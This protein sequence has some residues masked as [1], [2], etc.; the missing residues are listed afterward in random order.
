MLT[1]E[2]LKLK[3]KDLIAHKHEEEWF[4]FK[5]NWFEPHALGEYISALSNAAT[6]QGEEYGFFVWGVED[7]T[8]NV[9]GSDFDFHQDVKNEP[10]KHY[11]ARQTEP[12]IGF[13]F[14]EVT[15]EGKRLVVLA[16]PAA[17]KM[18]TAFDNVRYIRIGS[19]KE[20]LMRY[21]E[22]ESQ[23]FYVLR[24]G[25]P[26]I[27][28]TA[29]EY[30]DLTFN[31]LFVYFESK[32]VALSRRTFKKNLGLLTSEGKYN[33]LAQLLSDDSHI[34]IRF[35]LF[36]GDT[37]ASTMY[38]VKEF[39]YTCLLYSLDQVLDYGRVLNIPQAD[40]RD[41]RTVRKE[42]PLFNAEVYE[43]AVINAFV[44]NRWL[45]GNAPM[46]TGFR[47]RMEILS[48]G[49][50]PPKQTL[51]GFYD[52]VSVPVN[53]ALSRI[54][55]MLHITEHTGRGIPRITDVYGRD[56]ITLKEN[57]IMV[58]LPYDRLGEDVYGNAQDGNRNAQVDA[59]DG[60]EIAQDNNRNKEQMI[61]DYCGTAKSMVEIMAY[62]EV[63]DRRTVRRIIDPLIEQG[64]IAMTIPDKPNSKNQKYI[65]IR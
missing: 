1:S 14:R 37:K 53:E 48:R 44:H 29:S 46:F 62:L 13:E 22:H 7:N 36:A 21:P 55:I 8:H 32:G 31:K 51:E 9:A 40:E 3:I 23:L 63:K 59:Q 12:D 35:A 30:Q 4:E 34:T 42:V 2:E 57:T 17:Q 19:S 18:P 50:L 45:D 24:N 56:A 47:N 41:R 60:D 11:L 6:L 25:F 43:E 61:L 58:T 39:G 65:T 10:L 49:N 64:R 5:G 16:V 33:V 26:T 20:K 54:F 15:V 38:S 27:A 28:N 52:G